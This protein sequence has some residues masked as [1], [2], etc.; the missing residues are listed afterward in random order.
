MPGE[1]AIAKAGRET[2][3]LTFNRV[4][5]IE[6]RNHAARGHRPREYVCPPAHEFGR[7]DS[8][9]RSKQMDASGM[10][11]AGDFA[12]AQS[13]L[14]QRSAKVKGSGPG[15]ILVPATAPVQRA[16]NRF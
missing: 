3:D 9:A 11:A 5:E 7:R 16:R 4:R 6:P 1:H 14:L 2:F 10:I 8:V 13:D 15:G 12:F